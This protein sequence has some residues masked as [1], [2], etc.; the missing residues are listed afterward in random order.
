MVVVPCIIDA[1]DGGN[2]LGPKVEVAVLNRLGCVGVIEEVGSN[3]YD[4]CKGSEKWS[5]VGWVL[6]WKLV[7]DGVN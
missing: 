3:E 7:C 5:H 6:V 1:C 4:A 2:S